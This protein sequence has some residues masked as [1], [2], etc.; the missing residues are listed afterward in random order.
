MEELYNYFIM[1]NARYDIIIIGGGAAGLFLA[2]QLSPIKKTLI[3]ESNDR[4]GKKLLSTGNG[5]CNLTNLD[6]KT[7]HYNHPS[8]VE[9]FIDNYDAHDVIRAF[10]RMGLLTKVIDERVYPYSECSSN[11]LDVLRLAVQ[12]NG[13]DIKTGH[14]AKII[15]YAADGFT[16]SGV[17]KDENETNKS[18]EYSADY[19]VLATGSTATFG[20]SSLDLYT[21]FGHTVRPI[22]PSLVPIK[23]DK[24]SIKGLSGVRVKGGIRIGYRY[25]VGEILFKDFGVSGI[26]AFNM[27]NEI[28]R[29][30]AREGA[31]ILIDFM[32]EYSLSEVEGILNKRGNVTVGELL[33]GMFH[34][35][36][37][38]RLIA[39]SK[40]EESEMAPARV[41]S[42]AKVIKSYPI[43]IEGLGD[44]SLAQCTSGGLNIN[45]FDESLQSLKQKGLYAIGEVLDIDGDSG[46]FNLHW[47]WASAHAVALTLNR[48]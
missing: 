20:R 42:I 23:T 13:V 34:S 4:V 44:M 12:K 17:Y 37:A 7:I 39:A 48:I 40:S 24:E 38:A 18:F 46:G 16:V 30:V 10:E 5:K 11:V 26:A 14:F 31:N 45:E 22:Q 6:M 32:P 41:N 25:E 27:S 8:Y 9:Q 29:G 35:K 2:S 3:L 15:D 43:K 28:S 19:V 33:L 47:A 21:A 36:V 1:S